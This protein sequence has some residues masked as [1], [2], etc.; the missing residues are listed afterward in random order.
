MWLTDD[1]VLEGRDAP[2]EGQFAGRVSAG[3]VATW[4]GGLI[5]P[6]YCSDHLDSLCLRSNAGLRRRVKTEL[7]WGRRGTFEALIP[8]SDL[9]R[10]GRIPACA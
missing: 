6:S 8:T 5:P 3:I 9:S 4:V 10:S 7:L 1:A 2:R